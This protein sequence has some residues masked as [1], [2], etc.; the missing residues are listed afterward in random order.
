MIAS[1]QPC[2]PSRG[3]PHSQQQ[4]DRTDTA[5]AS[6]AIVQQVARLGG[7]SWIAVLHRPAGDHYTVAWACDLPPDVQTTLELR[8]AG[9]PLPLPA[10]T[11]ETQP[12]VALP[13]LCPPYRVYAVALPV[14]AE[15]PGVLLAGFHTHTP[16]TE[17]QRALLLVL[18]DNLGLRMQTLH[19]QQRIARLTGQLATISQLGQRTT[20]ILDRQQLFQQITRMICEALGYDHTQLLLINERSRAIELVHASGPAG[21]QLL[22]Q[23]FREAVGG[24][25]IIG[26]VARN[27]RIWVCNDVQQDPH[28]EYHHLLPHTAAE[29]ALPLRV[30]ERVIGVLDVQ[31]ARTNAFD[32]DDIFLLQILAD[33]IAP[34]LEN[35]RLFAAEHYERE[36]ATT[37]R[38]VSR[39]ICSSLELSQV[40]DL[41]L[42]QL[43]RVVPHIGTRITL[44]ST[45]HTMR[46]VAAKGYPDNE[47]A[48]RAVF[49]IEDAPL[50]P[51]IMYERQTVVV[52]D[53]RTDPRWIWLPGATQIR[54]WCGAPLVIKD[55]CIGFMCVD[56]G[57]PGFY[58]EN[59]ARIVR[60]FA[61]QAAVAIE[62]ARL[63]AAVKDFNEHLE[64]KVQQRTA[65]LSLAR[66]EIAAKAA[67]L[68][69]L[70]HR[71][72]Q[73]QEAE[74]QRI[75]HDLHDSITQDILGAIYELQ[76]IKRRLS[77]ETSETNRRLEAC[78]HLLNS[79]LLEMKHI[80]Y[81]LRPRALDELGL[82]AALENFARATE[83]HHQLQ[84]SFQVL[85]TAYPLPQDTELAIYRIVQEATQNSIRHAAARAIV[86][87]VE[88]RPEVLRV[89]VCD[90]GCGFDPDHSAAGL[91]LV[92]MRERAQ[93]LGGHLWVD[94][95]VE[96]GTNIVCELPRASVQEEFADDHSRADCR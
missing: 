2:P 69:A 10:G 62:N 7:L 72:V 32:D 78:Q 70:V 93:A 41:V 3:T 6:A 51:L 16:L 57:E 90:D 75:A 83:A 39:I 91:G 55:H 25:G 38:D 14:P 13:D 71:V 88:F 74:R 61:D 64:H 42:Q 11:I 36:L 82:L 23:G 9:A 52:E 26:W 19:L 1:L 44:R 81:E 15:V 31:S 30:G 54:S 37:L 18:A 50:A 35:A 28:Y 96:Q 56:W 46:V 24:K 20:S 53:A 49:E 4:A 27:G 63:Y 60:A 8:A 92:G 58:T 94:S 33:Q 47:E 66:D 68:R 43:D 22:R 87:T 12:V 73:V 5:D 21:A 29:I 76:A 65:E 59:H 84:V 40:L 79:T 67:Q 89:R 80:I 85:G 17:A 95:G 34:A 77:A 86:I 45:G 48:K